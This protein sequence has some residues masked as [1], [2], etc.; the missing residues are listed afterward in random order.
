VHVITKPAVTNPTTGVTAWAIY[1]PY[2]DAHT[3]HWTAPFFKGTD[4]IACKSSAHAAR[5]VDAH[6]KRTDWGS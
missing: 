5:I 2:V 1:D 6:L 3:A 4:A